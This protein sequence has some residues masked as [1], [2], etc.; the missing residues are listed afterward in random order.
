MLFRQQILKE[1]AEPPTYLLQH[2]KGMYG[3]I[4]FEFK[5]MVWIK[6]IKSFAS[7]IPAKMSRKCS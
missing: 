4:A 1:R 6:E 7:N 3:A 5:G 2:A